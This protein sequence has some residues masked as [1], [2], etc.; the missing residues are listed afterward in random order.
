MSILLTSET[1]VLVQ[2]ITSD[3]GARQAAAMAKYGTRLVGGVTP[4]KGGSQAAGLPVFDTV[5]EAV[6]ATGANTS[7]IYVAAERVTDAV[8]EAVEAG[9]KLI[10]V[11][12]EGMPSHDMMALRAIC[13]QSGA[14]LVGPNSLGLISP[15]IGLMGAFP[16][17]WAL[18]G[19]VGMFSR[20]GTLLL[21][22]ARQ[23]K[24]AGIGIS[25]A[26]HVG[27]DMVLGRN[28]AEY[29]AAFEADPGTRAI[30]LLSEVGGGKD[31]ESARYIPKMKKPVVALVVGKTV[32][33]GKAMGH[34]GALVGAAEH[35]AAAKIEVLKAAGAT[36]ADRPEDIPGLLAQAISPPL[37]KS[38]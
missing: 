26:V 23:L 32:P 19:S 15:G 7:V 2:G 1:R 22:S 18:P 14:W 20:G 36:I 37:L 38:A 5:R 11:A 9:I 24:E 8:I 12:A 27:G 25:T 31:S 30:V 33:T 10:Y 4:G 35:T 6:A 21:H 16:P 28:P 29:L 13:R 3:Y 17:E 34:A